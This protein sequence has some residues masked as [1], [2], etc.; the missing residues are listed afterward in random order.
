MDKTERREAS[1]ALETLIEILEKV[2]EKEN[3]SRIRVVLQCTQRYELEANLSAYEE[4]GQRGFE[5]VE[6][7]IVLQDDD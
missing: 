6:M 1:K 7:K 3:S 4:F 2:A 5:V